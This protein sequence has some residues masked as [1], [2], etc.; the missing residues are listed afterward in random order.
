MMSESAGIRVWPPAAWCAELNP[1]RTHMCDKPRG[2]EG[3]HAGPELPTVQIDEAA[4]DE[5]E[6]PDTAATP[7]ASTDETGADR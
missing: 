2:H 4:W 6:E 5:L 1:E 7:P 3:D